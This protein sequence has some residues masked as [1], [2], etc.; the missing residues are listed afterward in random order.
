MSPLADRVAVLVG[1]CFVLLAAA[2]LAGDAE[3]P[4]TGLALSAL[5][6][7]ALFAWLA[8]GIAA[9][10]AGPRGVIPRLGLGPGVLPWTAVVLLCLATLAWSNAL[11]TLIEL[12]RANERGTLAEID[13]TLAGARGESLGLSLVGIALAAGTAE[14]LF[15]RG[16]LQRGLER[17]LSGLRAAPALAIVLAALAFAAAHWDPV[18][19][20]AALALGL[21]LGLLA[22]LTG[23]VRAPIAA[24]VLNNCLAVLHAAF[25]V[26]LPVPAALLLPIELLVVGVALAVALRARP[27][28]PTG[29]AAAESP[30]PLPTPEAGPGPGP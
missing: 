9:L 17:R 6:T 1:G 26:V 30:H 15:F 13:R 21:W 2:G 18:H 27:P 12:F 14:E 4:A 7:A 29:N 25:G 19:S 3:P 20:P 23:G 22:W 28:P 11:D 5:A 16:L 10:R 8:I 24:H